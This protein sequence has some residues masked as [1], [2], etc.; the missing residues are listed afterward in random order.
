MQSKKRSHLKKSF[1]EFLKDKSG[2]SAIMLAITLPV[3]LGFIGMSTDVALWYWEDRKLQST[4]DTA[5][6]AAGYEKLD[7]S[8][9][10][11]LKA[12]V[13]TIID[14]TY[15]NADNVSVISVSS[16]PTSGSF[17][18]NSSA[19]EVIVGNQQGRYFSLL[20]MDSD[21]N[22]QSRAVAQ[23][24]SS[25][26]F[27]MLGLSTEED[28]AIN[29]TGN[30]TVDLNCGIGVNSNSD[31]ALYVNGTVNTTYASTVGGLRMG[32]SGVIN[33]PNA[34][35]ENG[36]S[37]TDPYGPDGTN[38]SVP[39]PSAC[40]YNNHVVKKNATI[41][42]GR[43]CGGLKL[44]KGTTTLQPGVYIID[45]G[46]FRT[47]SQAKVQGE[48]VTIIL[49]GSGTDYANLEIHGGSQFDLSAPEKGSGADYEGILIY[50]DRNAPSHQ[51]ANLIDNKING[52]S[53]LNLRGVIYFPQQQL[54]FNGGA[55]MS[56]K[57]LQMVAQAISFSGN[58]DVTNECEASDAQEEITIETVK[59]VE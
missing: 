47:T 12:K 14:E 11:V 30:A 16:P 45:G 29:I 31:E 37:I 21:V 54:T 25:G 18:G 9:I 1:G 33:S 58:A 27:C 38:L 28:R 59:L 55:T 6:L 39:A 43:Y 23:V 53:N 26:D 15:P 8:D 56:I 20:N 34:V 36:P 2:N 3:L 5:A 4:A 22:L 10:T 7:T 48:G 17:S 40:D 49:T 24:V 51:G 19:I 42:P 46:E 50:Q 52:G 57:C 41:N 32:G 13:Q 44:Q 35:V